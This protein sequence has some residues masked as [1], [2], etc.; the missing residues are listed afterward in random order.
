M[1][2]GW[3]VD[4]YGLNMGDGRET[5]G[6]WKIGVGVLCRNGVWVVFNCFAQGG[7]GFGGI[8]SSDPFYLF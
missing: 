5:D 1:E 2:G 8:L 4:Q 7:V 3:G 6:R